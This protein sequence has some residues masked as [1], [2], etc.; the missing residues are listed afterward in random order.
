MRVDLQQLWHHLAMLHE[1]WRSRVPIDAITLDATCSRLGA[2]AR[3]RW[4]FTGRPVVCEDSVNKHRSGL[5]APG[6]E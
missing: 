1:Y 5:L 3:A 6:G 2:W 4:F